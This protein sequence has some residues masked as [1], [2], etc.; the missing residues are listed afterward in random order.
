MTTEGNTEELKFFDQGTEV[1][2]KREDQNPTGSWKDRGTAVK[3][4]QMQQDNVHEAAISTSG[5]AAISFLTYLQNQKDFVLH[6][7]VSNSINPQKLEKIQKLIDGTNHKLYVSDNP[8]KLSVEI[9]AKQNC[10]N[11]RA[12]IDE[13]IVQGY[14]SLG[15]EL[16]KFLLPDRKIGL[17]APVSSGTALVGIVQ[18]IQQK[19]QHEWLMP[20]VYV[21]QSQSVH[22]IVSQLESH[23]KVASVASIE[24]TAAVEEQESSIAD[25]IIDKTALRAPQILKI[26]KETNGDAFAITNQEIAEANNFI[27]DKLKITL[28]NTSLLSVAGYLRIKSQNV[29]LDRAILIASGT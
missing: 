27:Q 20:S 22:P 19:I 2:L 4:A 11:L 6:V 9:A 15:F 26:I 14:W 25:A 17:F 13:R 7:A 18:G 24:K 28:S 16:K 1:I 21:C 12:S 5:N 23:N 29:K 3:V 8:R 10:I